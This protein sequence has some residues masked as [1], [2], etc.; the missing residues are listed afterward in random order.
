MVCFTDDALD[1]LI[2]WTGELE[3]FQNFSW[4]SLGS[5]PSWQT[6]NNTMEK[7]AE[8]TSFDVYANSSR[9]FEEFGYIKNYCTDEKLAEWKSE[10]LSTDK[11]W[12]EIFQHMDANQVPFIEFSQIIEYVLCFPGSSAPVERVFAKAKKVWKQES[13]ALMI[14]TLKSILLVKNNLEYDCI[15]FYNFLKTQPELLRKIASQDKYDF[16]QPKSDDAS[17]PGAMSVD[18]ATYVEDDE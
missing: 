17:S 3:S 16:K 15:N 4:V 5:L 12:V 18:A 10:N 1:Y 14:S 7:V 9:V 11:R 8:K 6:V 13:S 2:S